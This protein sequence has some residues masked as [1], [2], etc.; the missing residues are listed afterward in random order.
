MTDYHPVTKEELDL[1][2][3]RRGMQYLSCQGKFRDDLVQIILTRPDPLALLE[4]WREYR[5]INRTCYE[6]KDYPLW[7]EETKIIKQL[8]TNPEAVRQQGIDEGWWT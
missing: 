4:A 3:Q 5:S 2:C 6:T 1:M 8:R 7:G